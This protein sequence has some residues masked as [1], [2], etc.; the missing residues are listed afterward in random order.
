MY[1]KI[2]QVW[3][4]LCQ[5]F[6]SSIKLLFRFGFRFRPKQKVFFSFG[7]GFGRKEKWL[8]RP[9]S[10]SAE[11]KK[12]LSVV[13]YSQSFPSLKKF[14]HQYYFWFEMLRVSDFTWLISLSLSLSRGWNLV[15]D[16]ILVSRQRKTIW[17]SCLD[18][19]L[20]IRSWGGYR[21]LWP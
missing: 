2:W 20:C 11:M 16:Q 7:I 19:L 14:T 4:I 18:H 15:I 10:V 21:R 9:V 3:S 12:S 5:I 8:F 1:H 17:G 6:S 13:H